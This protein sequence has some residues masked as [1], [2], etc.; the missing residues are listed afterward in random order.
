MAVRVT[1]FMENF[2]INLNIVQKYNRQDTSLISELKMVGYGHYMMLGEMRVLAVLAAA[3]QSRTNSVRWQ[4]FHGFTEFW[5]ST[6]S[7]H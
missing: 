7:W 6:A 5:M 1:S 2:I 3:F 4:S